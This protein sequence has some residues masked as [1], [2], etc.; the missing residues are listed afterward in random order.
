MVFSL[1]GSCV[2]I[3][4]HRKKLFIESWLLTLKKE[5]LALVLLDLGLTCMLLFVSFFLFDLMSSFLNDAT[6]PTFFGWVCAVLLLFGNILSLVFRTAR[7]ILSCEYSV[8]IVA[9][10]RSLVISKVIGNELPPFLFGRSRIVLCLPTVL[11]VQ[12]S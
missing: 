10:L 12:G 9:L 2:R 8:K 5:L 3:S 11:S 7:S 6:Q 1:K 4:T